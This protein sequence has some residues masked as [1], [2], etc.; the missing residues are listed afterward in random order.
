MRVEPNSRMD[1]EALHLNAD[2]FM[3][4][5]AAARASEDVVMKL[6]R[7]NILET[8]NIDFFVFRRSHEKDIRLVSKLD[9]KPREM[10]L[11]VTADVQV[12]DAHHEGGSLCH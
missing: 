2:E 7:L 11:A 10:S 4:Y 8:D 9:R 5:H 6:A 3:R 1:M 12:A